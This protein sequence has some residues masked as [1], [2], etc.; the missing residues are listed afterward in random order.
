MS[1]ASVLSSASTQSCTTARAEVADTR[2]A[3]IAYLRKTMQGGT[4]RRRG[5][6]LTTHVLRCC[7]VSGAAGDPVRITLRGH[8]SNDARIT[9]RC[10]ADLQSGAGHGRTHVTRGLQI[11]ARSAVD[12][13]PPAAIGNLQLICLNARRRQKQA[14]DALEPRGEPGPGAPIRFRLI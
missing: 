14:S 6:R 1:L 9:C 8:E 11:I 5:R 13:C 3:L 4:A 2:T 12:T 7:R 10:H